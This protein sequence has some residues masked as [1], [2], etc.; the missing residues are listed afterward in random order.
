MKVANLLAGVPSLA[1]INEGKD[2]IPEV[3]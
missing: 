1:T 3:L 2:E